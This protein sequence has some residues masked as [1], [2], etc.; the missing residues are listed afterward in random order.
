MDSEKKYRV[1]ILDF[2]YI[3]NFDHLNFRYL[4]YEVSAEDEK[5]AVEKARK[6]YM[7]GQEFALSEDL[8]FLLKLFSVETKSTSKY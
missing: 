2:K 1:K 5:E 6:S 7:A 8:P 4:I 3:Q